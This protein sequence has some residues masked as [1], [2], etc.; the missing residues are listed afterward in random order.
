MEACRAA[1]RRLPRDSENGVSRRYT[2]CYGAVCARMNAE[3]R[4][5][6]LALRMKAELIL[7]TRWKSALPTDCTV[8]LVA[9]L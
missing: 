2:G 4:V 5:C 8:Q 3:C 6:L 1:V 7:G 9:V